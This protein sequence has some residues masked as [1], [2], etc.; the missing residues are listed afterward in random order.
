[1]PTP[2]GQQLLPERRWL[3]AWVISQ[4]F[5]DIRP[6]L[7]RRVTVVLFPIGIGFLLQFEAFT[8]VTLEEP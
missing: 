2:V 5:N 7:H 1:M 6:V 4:E 8:E 3:W